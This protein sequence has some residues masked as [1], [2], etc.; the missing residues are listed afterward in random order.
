VDCARQHPDG[1]KAGKKREKREWTG[2][3][4]EWMSLCKL[5]QANHLHTEHSTT[6]N[7]LRSRALN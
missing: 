7:A 2:K 4:E 1:S 3:W 5:C 6:T